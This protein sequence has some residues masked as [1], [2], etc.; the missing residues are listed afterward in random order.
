MS[1]LISLL[2]PTPITWDGIATIAAAILA[3]V[4][5]AL[6][7]L[8]ERRQ[9]SHSRRAEAYAG[10][11]QAVSDYLEAPYRIRRRTGTA[12]D[13]FALTAHVSEI[14]SRLDFYTA[15]LALIAPKVLDSYTALVSAARAEAGPQMSA[16]WKARPIRRDRDVPL[17]VA[18]PHPRADAARAVVLAL[19]KAH[20]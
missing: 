19:M 2:P 18:Y 7:F 6:S 17:V 5:V 12:V 4:I 16:A 8:H 20:P 14:Q 15:H 9:H 13:R 3:A 1:W 11:L 10:A